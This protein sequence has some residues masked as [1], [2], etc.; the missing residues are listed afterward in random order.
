MIHEKSKRIVNF[1]DVPHLPVSEIVR[2]KP[3]LG[4]NMAKL[5]KAA[6]EY[7]L[8]YFIED[9]L[10]TQNTE[11]RDETTKDMRCRIWNWI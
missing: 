4:L 6:E 8:Q 11:D 5:D 1:I 7:N 10:A 9:F 3:L 2:P